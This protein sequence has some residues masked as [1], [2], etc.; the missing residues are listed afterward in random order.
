MRVAAIWSVLSEPPWPWL[1]LVSAIGW[2]VMIGIQTDTTATELCIAPTGSESSRFW[3]NVALSL[4][5]ISAIQFLSAWLVMLIAMM[6]PILANPLC[7]LWNSSMAR[8]RRRA[9]A[10]FLFTYLSVWLLAGLFLVAGTVVLNG[11]DRVM[12]WPTGL[13]ALALAL[14]WQASPIKQFC[15]NRCHW[16]PRLSPLGWAADRDCLRFG[17]TNACWCASTCWTLMMVPLS[18][19][20]AHVPAMILV[21]AVMIVDRLR[22]ARRPCWQLPPLFRLGY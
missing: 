2:V 6:T 19:G 7:H 8:R 12:G 17:L 9:I 10:L 1:I 16:L 22:P 14:T 21:S 3:R 20:N 15:L 11:L 18:A 5:Q 13:I 4:S